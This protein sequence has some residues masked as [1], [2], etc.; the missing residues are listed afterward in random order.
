MGAVAALWA[1][2]DNPRVHAEL[3]MGIFAFKGSHICVIGLCRHCSGLHDS[4]SRRA[5]LLENQRAFAVDRVDDQ[6]LG[7]G[8][9]P[10][11]M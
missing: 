9:A 4:L 5:Q 10:P 8:E 3:F 7:L 1:K 11:P 6:V 2:N